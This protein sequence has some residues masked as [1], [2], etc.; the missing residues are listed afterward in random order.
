MKRCSKKKERKPKSKNTTQ[1][2]QKIK[3]IL[4]ENGGRCSAES[5]VSLCKHLYALSCNELYLSCTLLGIVISLVLTSCN[6]QL[7][8]TIGMRTKNKE[9]NFKR[10]ETMEPSSLS[11]IAPHG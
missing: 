4:S 5:Q 10:V 3:T 8:V 1:E 11:Y 6:P 9:Q 7:R 2:K